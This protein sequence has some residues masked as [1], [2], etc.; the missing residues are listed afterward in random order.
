MREDLEKLLVVVLTVDLVVV[1]LS[2]FLNQKALWLLL[3]ALVRGFD[4]RY[5]GSVT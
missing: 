5:V 2:I 1:C 3:Y 4:A